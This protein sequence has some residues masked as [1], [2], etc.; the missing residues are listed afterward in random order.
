[1]QQT[2]GQGNSI[3]NKTILKGARKS[4][5]KIAQPFNYIS[6]RIINGLESKSNH[7][8]TSKRL[9]SKR[10]LQVIINS[11]ANGFKFCGIFTELGIKLLETIDA[12]ENHPNGIDILHLRFN[13][14]PFSSKKRYIVFKDKDDLHKLSKSITRSPE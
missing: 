1:M 4:N 9:S 7:R 5:K 2:H 10:V 8:E 11:T 14:I 6:I 3:P 13:M 12:N